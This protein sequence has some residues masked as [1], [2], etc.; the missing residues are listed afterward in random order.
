MKHLVAALV[1]TAFSAVALAQGTTPASPSAPSASA[2]T[3]APAKS[4]TT[5]KAK[6][7]KAK[8]SD[9]RGEASAAVAHEVNNVVTFLSKPEP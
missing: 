2:S 7:K 1:V 6:K 3:S 8:K 5:K 9:G 4:G